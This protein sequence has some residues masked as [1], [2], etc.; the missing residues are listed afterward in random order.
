[1]MGDMNR[2]RRSKRSP[3][4]TEAL[5]LYFDALALRAG[6][7]A[8]ALADD[9]GLLLGGHGRGIDPEGIAAVAPVLS[10]QEGEHVALDGLLGLVTRGRPL[11]VWGVTLDGATFH[12]V[13]VGAATAPPRDAYEAIGRILGTSCAEC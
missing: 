6:W 7:D 8:V 12:L 10:A 5:S 13:T 3:R 2:E 11:K 1:M 4:P 9:D